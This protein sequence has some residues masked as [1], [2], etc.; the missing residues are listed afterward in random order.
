MIWNLAVPRPFLHLVA[1][2][3]SLLMPAAIAAAAEA[4]LPQADSPEPPPEPSV[5]RQ[6]PGGAGGTIGLGV[7]SRPAYSGGEERETRALPLIEYRWASGWFAGVR[8]GIGYSFSSN[9]TGEYGL[10]LGLDLG[11]DED[12]DPALDGLG[13]IDPQPVLGA[14]LS[15]RVAG[16]LRLSSVLRYGGGKDGDGLA[17]DLGAEAGLP[18]PSGIMLRVGVSTTWVNE[19]LV[20]DYY[21]IDAGQ[22]LRSGYP[23]YSPS[24][25]LRE[26]ELNLGLMFRFG[27]HWGAS[28]GGGVE[29]LLGDAK[30]SP[31]VQ[32]PESWS[33]IALLT[34]RF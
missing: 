25:G 27:K 6:G 19:T 31:I 11:R 3:S 16:P 26:A 8:D 34:R 7:A 29:R 22:S 13:D 32:E 18:L 15:G 5:G 24:A 10:S 30:D 2:L 4:A 14:F 20:Q 21:G 9:P 33:A 12:D 23:V 28:L 1:L 17:L